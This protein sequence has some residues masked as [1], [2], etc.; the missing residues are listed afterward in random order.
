MVLEDQL[1][2][3]AHGNVDDGEAQEAMPKMTKKSRE[4][5]DGTGSESRAAVRDPRIL[6]V[7]R[8]A[9]VAKAERSRVRRV[10]TG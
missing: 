8:R 4:T 7:G 3:R 6:F 10:G 9:S 5:K 2:R 1:R